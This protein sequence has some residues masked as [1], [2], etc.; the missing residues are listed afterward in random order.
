MSL[1]VPCPNCG[2]R[3][4][5]EFSYGGETN[6]RPEPDAPSEKLADYLFVRRNAAGSQQEWWYHRAG[7]RSWFLARRDTVTNLFV[8]SYWPEDSRRS[9]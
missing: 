5:T 4:F 2:L 1:L 3:E 7:C 6:G 9:R 8:E